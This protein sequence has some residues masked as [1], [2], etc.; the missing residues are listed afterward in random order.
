V[1]VAYSYGHSNLRQA[2]R[3]ALTTLPALEQPLQS[4]DISHYNRAYRNVLQLRRMLRGYTVSVFTALALVLFVFGF[5][6]I[7][8]QPGELLKHRTLMLG[9]AFESV[10]CAFMVPIAAAAAR[11]SRRAGW[12]VIVAITTVVVG[13]GVGDVLAF[14]EVTPQPVRQTLLIAAFTID[15]TIGLIIVRGVIEIL[16][17]NGLSKS[18]LVQPRTSSGF[19]DELAFILGLPNLTP[20]LRGRR[21]TAWMLGLLA[22]V[23]EG[24]Y[25]AG[26]LVSSERIRTSAIHSDTWG[27]N[28]SLWPLVGLA[29]A[30]P[31]LAIIAMWSNQVVGNLATW[32]RD[33]ARRRVMESAATVVAKDP[34]QPVLFLRS[35]A[36]NKVPLSKAQ[37]PWY[38]RVFDPGSQYLTLEDLLLHESHAHGPLVTIADPSQPS[39]P[40]GAARWRVA[41]AQWKVF[42]ETQLELA[43]SVV[44]SLAST[45][46][47]RWELETI[48][49]LGALR[50]TIFIVPPFA[51]RNWGHFEELLGLLDCTTASSRY[52]QLPGRESRLFALAVVV[53]DGAPI[54]FESSTFSELDYT[55]AL[56][57]A[58]AHI[59]SPT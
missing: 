51:T 45:A 58:F 57:C 25:V 29:L 32:L 4:I 39:I 24:T 49:R 10:L 37:F 36:S 34:R 41:D 27:H 47:V 44:V 55:V 8:G 38:L 42:L 12:T 5:V 3:V 13:I 28:V 21:P 7:A 56:R 2:L 30:L 54:V 50:K 22:A 15:L 35:F 53:R 43:G 46:G 33:S 16:R 1:Y 59:L 23:L 18:V 6:Y 48:K 9:L 20:F 26:L 40:V 11:G 52:R 31:V 14:M 17:A 19:W